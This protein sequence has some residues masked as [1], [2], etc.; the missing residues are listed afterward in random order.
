[1]NTTTYTVKG[2]TC[3]H[4]VA[5]VTEEITKLPTVTAVDVELNSVHERHGRRPVRYRRGP[6]VHP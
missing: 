4:R 1:M 2:M 3:G 5:A 6:L